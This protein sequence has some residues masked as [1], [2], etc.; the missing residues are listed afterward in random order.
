M[1]LDERYRDF[2]V[3]KDN[4]ENYLL[5]SI[6]ESCIQRF[7]V[8]IDTAWKHLKKYLEHDL[9]LNDIPN[10]PNIIFKYA[11]SAGVFPNAELWILFNH[12]RGDT[13]HDYCGDKAIDAFKMIDSFIKEAIHLYEI[14]T[15]ET[16]QK[17]WQ[18]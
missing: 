3:N 2:I 18:K 12:K 8:C 15:G 14:M 16:W 10:S 5:E 11:Q 4:L 7:E 9:G 17:S 6:Q 13:S 1:R